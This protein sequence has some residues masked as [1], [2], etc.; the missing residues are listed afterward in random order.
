MHRLWIAIFLAGGMLLPTLANSQNLP[1]GFPP[2]IYNSSFAGSVS[3]ARI[4]SNFRFQYMQDENYKYSEYDFA[5]S[6]DAFFPGIRSGIGIT[7]YK[8][9]SISNQINFK[10]E[11]RSIAIS[12]AIAPKISIKGKYTI[13][14]SLDINY[15]DE[16]QPWRDVSLQNGF[17]SRAGVLFN[18]TNYYI[19]YSVN[20]FQSK[21]L[22]HNYFSY[23]SSS[24]QMGYSFQKNQDSRFAFTP[25]LVLPIYSNYKRIVDWPLYN[26]GFRYDNYLFGA[27]GYTYF[28][29]VGLQV[30]WQK[31]GWR[32]LLS[33]IFAAN[34][35]A[36]LSLR[37]IFNQKD[38]SVM[39]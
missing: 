36:N 37:Y 3:N 20:L 7:A 31:K 19:G 5:A 8:N 30:G 22:F 16:Y 26:L 10:S 35:N 23:F 29:P 6:Y 11:S 33:S 1:G 4:C 17:S 13:S 34:Y 39:F 28:I 12:L 15:N 18:A 25:Q 2:L 14:P 38:D 24:L 27:I 32:I 21:D 9:K